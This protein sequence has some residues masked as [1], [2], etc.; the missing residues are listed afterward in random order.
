VKVLVFV[1]GIFG[2][3]CAVKLQDTTAQTM[4]TQIDSNPTPL[5]AAD[6]QLTST[7][8]SEFPKISVHLTQNHLH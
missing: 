6:L 7:R 4:A 8:K 5:K 1:D 3:D 2:L